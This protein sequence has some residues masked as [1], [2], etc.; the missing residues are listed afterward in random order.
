MNG[1]DLVLS[2]L[3]EIYAG[4]EFSHI[5]IRQVLEKYDYLDGG[6]KVYTLDELNAFVT[7]VAA[8]EDVLKEERNRVCALTNYSK[9]GQSA[10]RVADFIIEKAKL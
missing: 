8:G 6:E 1:R 5:L 10:A 7:R 2:M 9:D 4:N 3:K